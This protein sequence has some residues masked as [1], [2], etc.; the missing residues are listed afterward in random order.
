MSVRNKQRDGADKATTEDLNVIKGRVVDEAAR[1][2]SST[3]SAII[4]GRTD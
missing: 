3:D 2:P 4:S 1:D